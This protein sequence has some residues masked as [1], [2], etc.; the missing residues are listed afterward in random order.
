[1]PLCPP[2]IPHDQTR[3]RTWAT[4]AGSQW[5]TSWAMARPLCLIRYWSQSERH[6]SLLIFLTGIFIT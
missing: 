5:L 4:A 3:V 1:V 2:Q 6:I